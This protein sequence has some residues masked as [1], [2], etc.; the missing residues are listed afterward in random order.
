MATEAT[1]QDTAA[2]AQ[3]QSNSSEIF[4]L[5]QQIS[6]QV[7]EDRIQEIVDKVRDVEIE[8]HQ[9]MVDLLGMVHSYHSSLW[10]CTQ[11]L[12]L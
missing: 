1:G 4:A 6:S 12:Q 7:N 8:D 10:K 11:E 9:L 3:S 2:S 5:V